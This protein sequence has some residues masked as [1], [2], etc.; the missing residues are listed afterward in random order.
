MRSS[1]LSQWRN[2]KIGEMWENF[3]VL[4]IAQAVAFRMSWRR[5]NWDAGRLRNRELQ[6]L[7]IEWIREDAAIVT[8]VL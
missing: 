5:F 2:F 1:V 7:S 6:R 8:A 4:V 3:D